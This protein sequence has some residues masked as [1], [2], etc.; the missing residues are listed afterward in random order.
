MREYLVHRPD[1][2]A[3][4]QLLAEHTGDATG[5]ILRLAWWQGLLREEIVNLT[6]GQV[7]LLDRHLALPDRTVPLEAEMRPYLESMREQGRAVSPYVV[8]SQRYGKQMQPESVSRVIRKALSSVGQS[9]VRLIDLRHDYVIRQLQDHDWTYVS[10]I[11]GLTI[12][13]LQVHFSEYL[14]HK[15]RSTRAERIPD[16]QVDEFK[17]WK[18]LQSE[19]NTAAGLAMWMSW[20][21]GLQVRELVEL[22]WDQVDWA[23]GTLRLITRDVPITSA[24]RRLLED[25]YAA[26]QAGEDAHVLL[27]VQSR[28][29]VDVQRLS[30]LVRSALIRGGMDHVTLR[31]LR[32]DEGRLQEEALILAQVR[33]RGPVDRG[34]VMETLGLS[35]TA[36]YTR[37]RRMTEERKL[38]R[39]GSKYYLP[40]TVVPPEEHDAA[41]RA[42]L[43]REGFAYRKDIAELL[44]VEST[45]CTVILRHL[46]AAGTLVQVK[47]KYYLKEA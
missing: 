12:P 3:M 21:M 37:L 36:V 20:Q 32:R 44:R 43:V 11:T 31:D 8:V 27:S 1:A 15:D 22:T 35:K 10:R 41:I 17:L 26:R 4:A 24:V 40:G 25:T 6:W 5:M 9:D 2:A 23:R 7:S 46:V 13:G 29:P 38:V 34:G 19:K 45:Q 42:Y 47:Q 33:E 18:V 14:P 16:Q 39:V 28:K 30:K